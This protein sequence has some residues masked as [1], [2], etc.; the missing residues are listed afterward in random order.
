MVSAKRILSAESW[1]VEFMGDAVDDAR[2]ID[3]VWY[4]RNIITKVFEPAVLQDRVVPLSRNPRSAQQIQ[5]AG[6]NMHR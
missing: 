5:N 2:M 1:S 4:L 6:R 3:G